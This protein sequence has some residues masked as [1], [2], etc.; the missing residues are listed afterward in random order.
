MKNNLELRKPV[1]KYFTVLGLILIFLSVAC[2]SEVVKPPNILVIM[3]DDLGFSDL[4]CYGGEIET[5]NLDKLATGGLRFT[6]F[7]NTGRCWPSR[8][9]LLTGF[10]PQQVGRDNA[11]GIK[12]GAGRQR[13]DWASLLPV[14]LK[15]GGY[16]SYHSGKWHIDGM[17]IASGF[18]HSYFLGDQGRFFSPKSHYENDQKLPPVERG[19]GYYSTIA[20][21][22]KAIE[23]LTAHDTKHAD[24]PFFQYVA[25]TAPHFPLHALPEDIKGVGDRYAR[26]WNE[27]RK[28][29]WKRIQDLGIVKGQLSALEPEVGPPY[30]FSE[31][32][33]ILGEGEVKLPVAWESLT[34]EQKDF[35]IEKM[36]IHAAMVERMDK[37][38]GRILDQLE[39]MDALDNTL[40]IFLSDNGAS[41]ELMVRDDGHDPEAAPGSAATYLSLGPGW[42]NMCNTPFR[43]HKTWTHEGGTC[44]PFIAHWPKGIS[45]PG[46][47][48]QA[49]GHITD[50][51]PTILD[52]A[53]VEINNAGQ[54]P[55][56]GESLR[57]VFA[58]D[59]SWQHPVWYYHEGNRALRVGNWKLV[60]A[61]DEPWELFNLDKDRTETKNLSMANPQKV[62]EME[63]VW[64]KM[65]DDIR[66][67]APYKSTE[68]KKFSVTTDNHE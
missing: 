8:A 6:Q 67:D 5:P 49:H 29:R 42:S 16:R 10:Y 23:H 14:H 59:S 13:P 21:A 66:E 68:E 47:L 64:L 63:K 52:L 12:G 65:L 32:L 3:A 61:R 19:S 56:P 51:L 40:V 24:K 25:F 54:R 43:R 55:F 39:V 48:R 1:S 36:T 18:D 34:S 11:P 53:G 22:D 9:A 26:G 46:A 15:G 41:A 20:I 30:D 38:I 33:E 37:E 45:S 62:L 17:P 31:S 35:Q 44:T 4:G 28:E 57:S 60:A 27:L 7:N 2:T 50:I 58:Q